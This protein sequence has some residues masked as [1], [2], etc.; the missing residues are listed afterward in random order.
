MLPV[1]SCFHGE[2]KKLEGKKL[3]SEWGGC[4]QG[5]GDTQH[6]VTPVPSQGSILPPAPRSPCTGAA[7]GCAH[8]A[9]RG[10]VG[11]TSSF[12]F[13]PSPSANKNLGA[14]LAVGNLNFPQ[15]GKLVSRLEKKRRKF[16]SFPKNESPRL[17]WFLLVVKEPSSCDV[18]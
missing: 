7:P 17:M 13:F 9:Q 15:T 6:Q 3:G 8:P 12:F 10:A 16:L 1:S 4:W 5:T 18:W 11:R 2:E 14:A